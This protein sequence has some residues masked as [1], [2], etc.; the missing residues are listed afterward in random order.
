MDCVGTL[1]G[2]T[3]IA[4]RGTVTAEMAMMAEY[5]HSA[6]MPCVLVTATYAGQVKCHGRY[7]HP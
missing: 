5:M 7:L 4:R 1:D 2:D 3:A 6:A